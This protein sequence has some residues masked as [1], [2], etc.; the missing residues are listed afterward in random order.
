MEFA[1]NKIYLSK[2]AQ[3]DLI[4]IKTYITDVLINPSAALATVSKIMKSLQILRTHAQ[5]GALLS[6]VVEIESDYR[7]LAIGSYIA[8]YHIYGSEIYID[9]I[10]SS[11]RNYMQ[12]L[13]G[14]HFADSAESDE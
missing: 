7:F 3:N 12:I 14:D 5:A 1:M 4:E 6:S 9:R 8:F 10:L 2:E 13:F 11:R